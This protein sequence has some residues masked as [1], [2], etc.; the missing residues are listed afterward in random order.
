MHRIIDLSHVFVRINDEKEGKYTVILTVT[1]DDMDSDIYTTIITIEDEGGI[2]GFELLTL[3][4]ALIII[5][6]YKRK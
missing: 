3:L 6:F 2:P 5:Y 4:G 1:D